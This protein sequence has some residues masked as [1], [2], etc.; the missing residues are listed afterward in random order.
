MVSSLERWL[1]SDS[2]F[3]A[4]EYRI[5]CPDNTYIYISI[6]GYVVRGHE[7]R[8]VFLIGAATDV[9]ESKLA[10]QELKE[11]QQKLSDIVNFLP[12]ATF[13]VDDAGKVIA[14]N[15]AIEEMTGVEGN[16]HA[17]EREPRICPALLRRKETTSY[18]SRPQ[19][20]GRD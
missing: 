6:R 20:T 13:V 17:R 19:A 2:K 15:R 14:W 1:K 7:G 3:R 4:S 9:T 16:R 8:P 10:I 5:Q 12:D 11:S 18:R